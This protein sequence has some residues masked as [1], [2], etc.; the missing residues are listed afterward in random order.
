MATSSLMFPAEASGL[1]WNP[2]AIGARNAMTDFYTTLLNEVKKTDPNAQL[3]TIGGMAHIVTGGRSIPITATHKADAESYGITPDQWVATNVQG[4]P[5]VLTADQRAKV[6]AQQLT[7]LQGSAG[8][9]T[10]GGQ[11]VQQQIDNLKAFWQTPAG[12]GLD[13]NTMQPIGVKSAEV[14]PTYADTGS[15]G[16]TPFAGYSVTTTPVAKVTPPIVRPTSP[17]TLKSAETAGVQGNALT[18][19]VNRPITQYRQNL[20]SMARPYRWGRGGK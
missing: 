7:A 20:Q 13:P 17:A 4:Q 3:S 12:Q 9:E 16:S 8:P 10:V 18:P 2:Q 14:R 1:E 19:Q 11:Q 15:M 6:Q 5:L